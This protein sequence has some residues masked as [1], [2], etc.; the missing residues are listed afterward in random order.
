ML[1]SSD[2]EAELGTMMATEQVVRKIMF[3]LSAIL[4]FFQLAFRISERAM[5]TLLKFL[6]HF[7][8]MSPQWSTRAATCSLSKIYL[9]HSK[10]VKRRIL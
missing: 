3:G 9:F 2:E 7:I 5:F 4:N 1:E 6:R 8:F 10:S